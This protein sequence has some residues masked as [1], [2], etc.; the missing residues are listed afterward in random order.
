MEN[1]II[2]GQQ[3]T[4]PAAYPPQALLDQL[5]AWRATL[6]SAGVRIKLFNNP[7]TCTVNT[8]LPD[9]VESAA[10]GYA[11][12]SITDLFGPYED[13]NANAYLVSDMGNFICAGGGSDLIY[14]AYLVEDIGAAATATF[15]EVGGSYTAPVVTSGGTGY[16]VPPKITP[17]GATGSGAVLQAVLT[18]GVVTGITII[19]PGTGYT[20]ATAT[21]EAPNKLIDSGNFPS[22]KPLQ[23]TTDAIQVAFQLD[24]L[25]AG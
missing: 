1:P 22:P 5:S 15:T 23:H 25:S 7:V 4:P 9:L 2:L 19:S 3:S 10:P 20:T 11:P 16:I 12:F 24:M 6:L 14:G 13:V 8:V 21:I 17:T 18:G